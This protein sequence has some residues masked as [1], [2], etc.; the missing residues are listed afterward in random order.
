MN[1]EKI[2]FFT[3]QQKILKFL[4]DNSDEKYYDRQ[5]SL[6][7]GV[8]RAGTNFAL[9]DLT[10]AG[11]IHKEQKGK[12][13]FY[14]LSGDTALAKEIKIVLNILSINDMV[15][16]AREY[17]DKIVLFG[18]AAKGENHKASDIDLLFITPEKSKVSALTL[19]DS[20]REKLQPVIVTQNEFIKMKID[21][22]AF[23]KEVGEGK[24]LW[25]RE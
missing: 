9:R 15:M 17:C 23:Y 21:N 5:I 24:V 7:S 18:S 6:L 13:N 2:L 20:Q 1:S 14:H 22:L 16:K 10:L 19:K 12:M 25:I 11:L 4:L 8:S 3:N